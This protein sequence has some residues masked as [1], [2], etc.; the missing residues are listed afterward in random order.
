VF[1]SRR[2][3]SEPPVQWSDQPSG[4]R[5][6]RTDDELNEAVDRA[7]RQE[8]EARRQLLP[9]IGHYEQRSGGQP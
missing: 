4:V 6:L 9:R 8:A 2:L 3:S 5:V 7:A 1:I